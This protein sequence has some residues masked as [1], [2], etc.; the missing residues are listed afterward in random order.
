MANSSVLSASAA[1]VDPVTGR[2]TPEFYRLIV[3]LTATA[4]GASSG[5]VVTEPS[6][7]LAGGGAVSDGLALS[8]ADNGVTNSKIRQSTGTSVIG[9]S[10]SSTGNVADIKASLNNTVLYRGGNQLYFTNVLAGIT[11][12][13]LSLGNAAASSTA[14]V[15]HTIEIEA[16]GTTY[17]L[18][19]STTP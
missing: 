11:L 10:A 16:D 3:A 15:T 14:T 17:Y 1:I 9:R 18:L 19:A 7:G 13:T 2:P 12:T 5:E 8:I 6:S 4:D